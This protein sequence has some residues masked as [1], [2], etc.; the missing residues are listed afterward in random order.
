MQSIV[1]A[2]MAGTLCAFPAGILNADGATTES[3]RPQ[4]SGSIGALEARGE[5]WLVLGNRILTAG[6]STLS[7]EEKAS[8][9][10]MFEADAGII[11]FSVTEKGG[12]V[13]RGTAYMLE[14][15]KSLGESCIVAEDDGLS[16]RVFRCTAVAKDGPRYTWKYARSVTNAAGNLVGVIVVG[17]GVHSVASGQ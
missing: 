14:K 7:N 17:F 11:S 13:S 4:V 6:V 8:I 2:L 16:R 5:Q 3:A 12:S 1:R 9:R 15:S 10:R